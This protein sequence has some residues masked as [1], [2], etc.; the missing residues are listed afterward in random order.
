[1]KL[2]I[3]YAESLQIFLHQYELII[4]ICRTESQAE[5][6]ALNLCISTL[7]T[8]YFMSLFPPAEGAKD[9]AS[10]Y[11]IISFRERTINRQ[12]ATVRSDELS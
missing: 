3:Y 5:R 2:P 12:G 6:P 8:S 11:D 1:M 9:K 10:P 4:R 7:I